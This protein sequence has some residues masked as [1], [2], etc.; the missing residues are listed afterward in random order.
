MFATAILLAAG[1]G[2]RMKSG[3]SKPLAKLAGR[4]A[5]AYSL[6]ALSAHTKIKQVIIV[7]NKN[8]YEGILQLAGSKGYSKVSKI[9]EGGERRQDSLGCG[10]RAL[11][12]RTDTVLIHDAARP[13]IGRKIITD[14]LNEAQKSGAAVAGVPVK[15]TIKKSIGVKGQGLRVKETI[16]RKGLWEIQTPQVFK[17]D[18]ILKAFKK[19]GMN[20]VTDDAALIE[21]LGRRVKIVEGSYFNIKI[22]TPEDLVLAEAIARKIK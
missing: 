6:K 14:C 3:L 11:D 2:R 1:R 22:T 5:I 8:N 15:A 7:V 18:L 12:R 9:I 20:D 4:P 19:F 17:K 21:K 16:D 10:L 13:F